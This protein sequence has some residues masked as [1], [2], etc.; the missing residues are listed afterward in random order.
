M[1]PFTEDLTRFFQ[2]SEFATAA[3]WSVGPATVNGIFDQEYL[4]TLGVDSANPVFLCRAADMPTAARGQTLTINAVVYSI[5]GVH[6]D[7][8][9]VVTLE[10]RKSS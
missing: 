6:P 7:G 1:P 2:T 5:V 3:T 4:Q 9:G 8:T 10:L